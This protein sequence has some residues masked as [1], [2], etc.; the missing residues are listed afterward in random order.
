M[1]CTPRVVL[2][3]VLEDIDALRSLLADLERWLAMYAAMTGQPLMFH[4]GIRLFYGVL[5]MLASRA[6]A[7]TVETDN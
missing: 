5:T 6:R 2:S 3:H 7:Q 4:D 1:A